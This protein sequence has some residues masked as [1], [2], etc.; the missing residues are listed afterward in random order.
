MLH[1]LAFK[2]GEESTSF[3]GVPPT[4]QKVSGEGKGS[5]ILKGSDRGQ[6]SAAMWWRE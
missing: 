4:K 2:V 3:E 5:A 6:D 1:C